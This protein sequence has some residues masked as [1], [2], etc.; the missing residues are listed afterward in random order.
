MRA[1]DYGSLL[2]CQRRGGSSTLPAR[3]KI[4][5]DSSVVERLPEEQGVGGSIPSLGTIYYREGQAA[6]C[7]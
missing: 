7:N 2:R 6:G 4:C 1:K 3:A 5:L